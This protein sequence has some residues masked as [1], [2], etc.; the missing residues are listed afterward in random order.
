MSSYISITLNID[1]EKR[2]MARNKGDNVTGA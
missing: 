2:E 1:S